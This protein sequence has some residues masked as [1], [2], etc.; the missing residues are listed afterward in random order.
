MLRFS[1]RSRTR[2]QRAAGSFL[3]RTVRQSSAG[4]LET[5]TGQPSQPE[6][7]RAGVQSQNG[8]IQRRQE[9]GSSN[10]SLPVKVTSP[11][12]KTRHKQGAVK[13]PEPAYFTRSS[14]SSFAFVASVT[15]PSR[16]PKPRAALASRSKYRTRVNPSFCCSWVEDESPASR[17]SRS[18]SI[19]LAC[20]RFSGASSPPTVS[21]PITDPGSGT[22]AALAT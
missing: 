9:T 7:G 1:W 21:D 20:R 19:P 10:A 8:S 3:L 6:I 5:S 15:A 18:P 12:G 11:R 16:S 22:G 4:A 14:S 13:T 17:L 2:I